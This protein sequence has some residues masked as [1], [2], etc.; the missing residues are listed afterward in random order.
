MGT[1]YHNKPIVTDGLVFYIDAA[2][3]VSYPGSGTSVTDLGGSFDSVMINGV[4]I[5]NSNGG[6]FE[7][8]GINDYITTNDNFLTITPVGTSTEYTLEAWI[9][10]HTSAGETANADHIIGHNRAQ[11]FGFQVGVSNSNPRISY[12]SRAT[13]NF[14]SSEFSYNTWTHVVLSRKP[15]FNFKCATYLNGVNDVNSNASLHIAS[16]E[17]VPNVPAPGTVNIG[18]GGGRITGYFDG[19]MG[20]VRV[21]NKSLT[22]E[23]V[24]QNYNAQKGRFGL[25]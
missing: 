19:L 11:G 22:A 6:V 21:Y 2:N 9:Y 16:P 7:F 8:D 12:G 13:S 25:S 3:K 20:P 18:G 5:N 4:A 1:T 17:E 24:T 23:E 14:Y 10:V 15:T